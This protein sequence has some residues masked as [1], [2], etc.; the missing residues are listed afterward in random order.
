M[1]N[2]IHTMPC[3]TIQPVGM[4]P[5]GDLGFIYLSSLFFLRSFFIPGVMFELK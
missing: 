5:A 1:Y 2:K 4:H 3:H